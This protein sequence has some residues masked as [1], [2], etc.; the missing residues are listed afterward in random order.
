MD[1]NWREL[2][3]SVRA[4]LRQSLRH[5]PKQSVRKLANSDEMYRKGVSALQCLKSSDVIAEVEEGVQ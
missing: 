3:G 1:I 5:F 2:D 4:T